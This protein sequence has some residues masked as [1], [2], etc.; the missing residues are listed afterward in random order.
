M[1]L[2]IIVPNVSFADA[3]LGKVTLSGNVPI[4]GIYINLRDS[5]IGTTVDLKCSYLPA[6]TTQRNVIW[7]I[8][9][10]NEYASVSGSVLT[11]LD[12]ANNNEVVVKCTNVSNPYISANKTIKV[13]YNQSVTGL[14]LSW[15]KTGYGNYVDT[16]IK[17]ST[18]Q[19]YTVYWICDTAQ[20]SMNIG[21]R[22]SDSTNDGLMVV[23]V[24]SELRVRLFSPGQAFANLLSGV[25]GKVLKTVIDNVDG[26]ITTIDVD[27]DN[28]LQ[29]TNLGKGNSTS[30]IYLFSMNNH[31]TSETRVTNSI[32][33][34][35]IVEEDNNIVH[36]FKPKLVKNA[37]VFIDEI[38]GTIF[39]I[40]G[41]NEINYE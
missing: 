32:I 30:N 21:V 18:T 31:G 16:G 5:Y 11:I 38:S 9:S 41:T 7:S 12:G 26:K 1:G 37:P 20:T 35:F 8:E 25:N 3:N 15:I 33:K 10:G 34:R 2:A 24:N 39:K 17:L 23:T 29:T 40:N 4:K 13:T 6:N 27:T 19:K 22:D 28:V 14:P 36:D